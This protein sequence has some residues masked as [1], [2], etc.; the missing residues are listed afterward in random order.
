MDDLTSRLIEAYE[1]HAHE[2]NNLKIHPFKETEKN[3]FLRYLQQEDKKTLLEI[4][5]G[6]GHDAEFFQ[7]NG[8]KVSAIDF[9]PTMVKLC[10]QRGISAMILNCYNLD[11]IQ[12][13]FDAVYSMNCL[14]HIPKCDF[15]HILTL[16]YNRMNHNGLL[17]LGLWGGD[18]FEGIWD[19]DS[20]EPKRFFAFYKT[21]TLLELLLRLFILEYYHRVVPWDDAIFNSIILRRGT[22]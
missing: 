15:D 3:K 20:Y 8:F 2:R 14:V 18:D 17:Y 11:Q 10:Q 9:A 13:T 12:D 7:T 19:G 4:G 5:C 16:I 22:P 21:T 1:R 6:P